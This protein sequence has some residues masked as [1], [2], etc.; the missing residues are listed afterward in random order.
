MNLLLDFRFGLQDIRD[1]ASG[2]GG[3]AD[4]WQ[5]RVSRL[6]DSL[7]GRAR[8]ALWAVFAGSG[9]L[10]LIACINFTGLLLGRGVERS[11]EFEVRW[12]VG[13]SLP[14]I[15]R[16]VFA[17]HLVLGAMAGALGALV[18]AGLVP[19]LLRF[20]P[21]GLLPRADGIRPDAATLLFSL[22]VVTAVVLLSATMTTW[23]VQGR[24]GRERPG[25]SSRV[26]TVLLEWLTVSEKL[27][28]E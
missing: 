10:L 14:D 23:F 5:V 2:S 11:L 19:A 18:S 12:A 26:S 1:A 17:E 9:L 7:V 27:R 13:A 6:E 4:G 20:A 16:Q 22:G 21:P 8:P 25:P 28:S 3:S 15:A 24:I